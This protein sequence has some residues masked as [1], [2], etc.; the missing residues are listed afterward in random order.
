MSFCAV[1][2]IAGP[3]SEIL[4]NES[5]ARIWT[6]VLKFRPLVDIGNTLG[7][8]KMLT[9]RTSVLGRERLG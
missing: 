1:V 8:T 5:E 6:Q 4:L 3:L 2:E 7:L 9:C